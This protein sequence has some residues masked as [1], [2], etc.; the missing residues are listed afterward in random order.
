M[1][2]KDGPRAERA[3]DTLTSKMSPGETRDATDTSEYAKT[4]RKH[5]II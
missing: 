5:V 2:S 4:I 1:T 3:K